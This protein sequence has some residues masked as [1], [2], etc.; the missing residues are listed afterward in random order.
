N[1]GA[2]YP[3]QHHFLRCMSESQTLRY[4]GRAASASP[5]V[6]YAKLHHEQQRKLIDSALR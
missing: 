2:W 6:G 4:A 1:Q 3:T 5:A